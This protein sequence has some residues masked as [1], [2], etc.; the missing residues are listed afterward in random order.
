[1]VKNTVNVILVSLLIFLLGAYLCFAGEVEWQNISRENLDLRTVLVNPDN[2]G[3]IY[4]GA[5][6]RILKTEDS[7]ASWRNIFSIKGQNRSV[8]FLLFDPWDRNSLYAATGNGLF[9]S[10][11]QG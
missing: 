7:G 10:T 4:A 8:N 9:Y 6:S 5:G 1:M 11:N 2:P 3:I